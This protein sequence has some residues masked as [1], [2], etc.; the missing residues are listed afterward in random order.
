MS[1]KTMKI[2]FLNLSGNVGKT[3]L[4]THLAGAFRPNA[5]VI[6]VETFNNNEAN[7]VESIEVEEFSASQF[8][9]IYREIMMGDDLIIDVG[10]S[11]VGLFMEELTRYKG[12]IGEFDLIVVPTVP[13]EKQ[14][15]DT[16]A[17]INWLHNLGFEPKKI[18]VIFNQHEGSQ[19]ISDAYAHVIGY[20]LTDGEHKAQWLPHVVVSKNDVF[21][22]VTQ[23][24]KTVSEL[25]ADNTDW[26]E[27]RK[28]AKAAQ[29]MDALDVA[30]DGE[31]ASGL[32]K[33]AH[34][35]LHQAYE[36]LLTPYNTPIKGKK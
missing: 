20:A 13:E 12:S 33:S 26:K 31:I 14:Q 7:K 1:N 29:D 17:T 19:T 5:K 6:S 21:D 28:E 36:D 2:C 10:S 35:N 27:K 8:R 25:A 3:T 4:S 16:I 22:I 34:P 23:S 18:R 30:I 9:N 15:R 11:N 24:H 32:A